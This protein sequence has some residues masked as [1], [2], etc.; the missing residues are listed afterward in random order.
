MLCGSLISRS[1]YYTYSQLIY[2][3]KIFICKSYL[4]ERLINK[5]KLIYYAIFMILLNFNDIYYTTVTQ[6]SSSKK[7]IYIQNIINLNCVT[8]SHSSG[9][10]WWESFSDS[11]NISPKTFALLLMK[12]ALSLPLSTA[13]GVNFID[14]LHEAFTRTDP[15][16]S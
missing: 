13:I 15:K 14:I 6:Q 9:Q 12:R 1:W 11:K 8:N 10:N 3:I 5:K 4:I 2:K 16:C 7:S